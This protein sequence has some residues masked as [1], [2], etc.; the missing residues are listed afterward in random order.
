MEKCSVLSKK[1][2]YQENERERQ[3]DSV[4]FVM[5]KTFQKCCSLLRSRV[6]GSL[7]M[8]QVCEFDG[9]PYMGRE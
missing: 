9:W 2:T 7:F 8:V 4:F 3:A 1:L 5:I 6:G